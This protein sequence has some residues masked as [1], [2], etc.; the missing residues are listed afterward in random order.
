[1]R[2]VF[3]SLLVLTNWNSFPVFEGRKGNNIYK[4]LLY[5]KFCELEAL[6]I[7]SFNILGNYRCYQVYFV[8]K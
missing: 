5:S 3:G 4:C 2:M 8:Y 1:M 7:I 6:Q